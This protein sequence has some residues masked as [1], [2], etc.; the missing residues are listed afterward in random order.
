MLTNMLAM[1]RISHTSRAPPRSATIG[2]P[3]GSLRTSRSR[4][5]IPFCQPVPIHRFENCFLG[6]PTSREVLRGSL[7]R[8]AILDFVVCVD[9][10]DEHFAV[11]LDHLCDPQAFDNVGANSKNLSHS[12]EFQFS[13]FG[14]GKLRNNHP[15]TT[16]VPTVSPASTSHQL[17]LRSI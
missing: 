4:Q 2:L 10:S 7:S 17:L 9:A 8:L 11:P 1:P 5:L 6:S 16:L 15:T 13:D 14:L 3:A 12:R